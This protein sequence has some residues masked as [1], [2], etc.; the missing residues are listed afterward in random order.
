[1]TYKE[2]SLK[3]TKAIEIAAVQEQYIAKL[4]ELIREKDTFK[5]RLNLPDIMSA[6][7]SYY[8]VES[9]HIFGIKRNRPYVRPRQIL[10]Y[11]AKYNI[12]DI[13][14]KEIGRYLGNRDHSTVIHSVR[15]VE[16]EMSYNKR[17]E[18]EINDI[19]GMLNL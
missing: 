4:E 3:H 5:D 12:P 8:Q 15:S 7:C 19:K 18:T 14:L 6:V 9:R 2:L 1:M 10:C 13:T 17:F 16:D 11:I